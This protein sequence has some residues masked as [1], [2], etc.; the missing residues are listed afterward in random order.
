MSNAMKKT[1]IDKLEKDYWEGVDRARI[2]L[3]QGLEA[4]F[5]DEGQRMLK[6]QD[7]RHHNKPAWLVCLAAGFGELYAMTVMHFISARDWD[8]DDF[9]QFLEMAMQSAVDHG[10]MIIDRAAQR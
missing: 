7:P 4:Y 3:S 2:A 1:T 10:C 8:S 6:R 5:T 9:K